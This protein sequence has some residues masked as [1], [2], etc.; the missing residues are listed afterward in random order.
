[1]G[2]RRFL[3]IDRGS[4]S[5][6]GVLD[7]SCETD[8]AHLV[9]KHVAEGLSFPTSTHF[10]D[11]VCTSR[12]LLLFLRLQSST[13]TLYRSIHYTANITYELGRRFRRYRCNDRCTVLID[14]VD[15]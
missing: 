13:V 3:S 15:A 10:P 14:R 7:P 4:R 11:F 12:M 2:E 1:M 8:F 5:C 6:G 9:A